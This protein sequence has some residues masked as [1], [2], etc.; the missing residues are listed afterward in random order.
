MIVRYLTA[1]EQGFYYTFNSI[2][3]LQTLFDLGLLVVILQVASHE[4]AHL[5]WEQG[6]LVG[7][8]AAKGRLATLLSWL[9]RWYSIAGGT[10]F[11]LL[12]FGGYFFFRM[13]APAT[14]I[15]WRGP[16]I[17]LC[18]ICGLNLLLNAVLSFLEGMGLVVQVSVARIR[19]SVMSTVILWLALAGKLHLVVAPMMLAGIAASNCWF[20]V[21]NWRALRDLLFATSRF[22]LDFK[23]EIW[24]FQWRL[25][26]TSISSYMMT[27]ILNPM[28]FARV[29]AS[30]AG[31]M[32]MSL[33]ITNVPVNVG[34][35]WITTKAQRFGGHVARKEID[36][37]DHLFFSSLLASTAFVTLGGALLIGAALYFKAAGFT[38]MTRVLSPWSLAALMIAGMAGHIANSLGTYIRASKMEGL[39][40]PTVGGA[41]LFAAM[42]FPLAN[43][44]GVN[45]I[46]CGYLLL[47]L[48]MLPAV[49]IV[50]RRHRNQ[51]HPPAHVELD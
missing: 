22:P 50:F 4:H 19:A 44:Y 23:R 9:L 18:A 10:A 8:P 6:K 48:L 26:V 30:A 47:Q 32:G 13:T 38:F 5:R 7:D 36:K 34:T 12:S 15:A 43:V 39:M 28:V 40:W 17:A 25:G 2:L 45:G 35:A 49:V 14:H 33:T 27:Q 37:L 42:I 3:A 16:W 24:P 21:K 29:G 41:V 46:V 11:V 1:Q 31:Q 20:V 51:L